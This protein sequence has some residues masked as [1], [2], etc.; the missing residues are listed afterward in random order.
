MSEHDKR[1]RDSATAANPKAGRHPS[2]LRRSMG[3]ASGLAIFALM[4]AFDP[5]GG[6]PEKAWTVAT[7]GVLMAVWWV[8]EAIPIPATA[9][10]PIALFPLLDVAPIKATAAP[11]ANPLIFLF[12]GGFIIALAMERWNLHR[13]IALNILKVVGANPAA[14]VGGFMGATAFLSMWVSNT[15]TATMMLPIGLSVIALVTGGGLPGQG[16]RPGERFAPALL[17]GIAYGASIGGI[18]TLIGTPPN[19]LLAGYFAETYHV[20]ISFANWMLM[21]VPLEAALLVV[22]WLV[23]TK[24]VFPIRVKE[25][26]G[27]EKIIGEELD[28]LGPVGRGEKLIAVIFVATALMWM[29]RPIIDRWLPGVSVTD[30]GIAVIAALIVFVVPVEPKNRVFL[31]DW[32]AT[33]KLPWG[34]LIL[35]G[36]GLSLGAAINQT[37]LSEWIATA[38]AGASGWPTLALICGVVVAVMLISHMTSNTAT[39]AAFLPLTAALAVSLGENP[40]LLTIPMVLAASC[41]FMMPVATPPNAIVFAS[42]E[43]TV[44]QMARAGFLINVVSLVLILFVAYSLMELAFG[45]QLGVVPEW[46]TSG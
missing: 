39:A 23:L 28:K 9:L 40:L 2:A 29:V 34:V 41:V 1:H 6:M 38:M 18:G 36:G 32:T 16:E 21:A 26:T 25:L 17:L 30:P 11:Y 19:A 42:G 7:V 33:Q 24:V 46:A 22:A 45:I 12:L 15:A 10:V 37:G 8:L 5:P 44:P 14:L 27:V 13:R 20:E 43:L 4:L 31:L 35:F 3:L